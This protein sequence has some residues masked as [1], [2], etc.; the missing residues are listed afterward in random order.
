MVSNKLN[1]QW[2]DKKLNSVNEKSIIMKER[3]DKAIQ[4]E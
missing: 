2:H 4:S 3:V 1:K